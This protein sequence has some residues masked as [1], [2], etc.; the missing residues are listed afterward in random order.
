M[1]TL[2]S[3]QGL[4]GSAHIPL[5]IL[6][7][8]ECVTGG[9]TRGSSWTFISSLERA[10][11]E[12]VWPRLASSTHPGCE[13]TVPQWQLEVSVEH[14]ACEW[15]VSLILLRANLIA[16]HTV[17]IFLKQWDNYALERY[18]HSLEMHSAFSLTEI[19]K[20]KK[21]KKRSRVTHTNKPPYPCSHAPP[22]Q[23]HTCRF[24]RTLHGL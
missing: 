12:C 11:D 13:K 10:G 7:T 19:Q 8:C 2:W 1:F 5:E 24:I 23:T 4:H 21:K 3:Y 17:F 22:L 6:R 15:H 9:T 14:C 18:W 16:F 20:G